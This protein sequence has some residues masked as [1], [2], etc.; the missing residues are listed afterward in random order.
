MSARRL[1]LIAAVC[2]VLG[3]LLLLVVEP[4]IGR[5]AGVPLVFVGIAL[6]VAAI[7]TPEFLERDR[8]QPE[9]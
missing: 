9:R 5:I 2:F 8:Y 4:A 1:P 3:N 7:A 6:G